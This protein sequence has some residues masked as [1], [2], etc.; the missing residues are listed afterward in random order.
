MENQETK[1]TLTELLDLNFVKKIETFEELEKIYDYQ[2][3]LDKNELN[4]F[5]VPVSPTIMILLFSISISS[6]L[7][8]G[9]NNRL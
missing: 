5:P 2:L 6:S 1:K 4:V 8:A 3:L 9:C 7:E